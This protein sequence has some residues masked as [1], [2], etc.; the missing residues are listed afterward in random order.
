MEYVEVAKA[1]GLQP[2]V[3]FYLKSYVV[4]LCARF[5]NYDP[6]FTPPGSRGGT[7]A[8]KKS[9]DKASQDGAKKYLMRFIADIQGANHK[10]VQKIGYAYKRAW[11]KAVQESSERLYEAV[12]P[13]A[14]VFHGPRLQW[15][16]FLPTQEQETVGGVVAQAQSFAAEIFRP[17]PAG[18]E[19]LA[20]FHGID[21]DGSDLM[22]LPAGGEERTSQNLYELAA[23]LS[24]QARRGRVS[25]VRRHAV[26]R[27]NR[28]EADLRVRLRA[29]G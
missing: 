27:L 3:P 10:V 17:S 16:L 2:D 11:K 12:G 26:S 5:I 14:D 8:S 25:V 13:L 21:A 29:H 9:L 15:E 19:E 7:P 1:R 6:R 4:G 23:R 18:N 28:Q 20:R 24:G 22:S